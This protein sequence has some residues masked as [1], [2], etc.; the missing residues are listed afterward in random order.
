MTWPALRSLASA[1]VLSSSVK[2]E[3]ST[4]TRRGTLALTMASTVA[5]SAFGLGRLGMMD[6]APRPR[7]RAAPLRRDVVA[8]HAPAGGHEVLRKGAA[9]DAEADDADGTFLSQNHSIPHCR[10]AWRGDMASARPA[11]AAFS[12]RHDRTM[13]APGR[14]RQEIAYANR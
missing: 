14:E 3:A 1:A 5:A 6:L 12:P 2:V 10:F 7:H 4:M 11:Q 8:D 9:H 13:S